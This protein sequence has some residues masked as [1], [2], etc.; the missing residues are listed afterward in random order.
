VAAERRRQ[1]AKTVA[2]MASVILDAHRWEVRVGAIED[3]MRQGGSRLALPALRAAFAG[4]PN[5]AV[6]EAAVLSL[7]ELG[8]S[9]IVERL[10]T[11]LARRHQPA[12]D[13]GAKLAARALGILGDVRGLDE[14][15]AAYAETWK[16]GIVAGALRA[17]GPAALEPMLELLESRPE[18]ASRK[19]VQAA[20]QEM[21]ATHLADVM[22]RRLGRDLGPGK[23]Y[24]KLLAPPPL[25]GAQA[26]VASAILERIPEGSAASRDERALRKLAVAAAGGS[27]AQ[28]APSARSSPS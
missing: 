28:P 19:P 12:G 13:A 23:L 1:E 10:V 6:R 8:D 21:P 25:A 9:E 20:I 5:R 26:R 22:V 18:L 7:A 17:F 2:G 24:L 15:L 3:L 4:D 14:L 11:L 16:P 27:E